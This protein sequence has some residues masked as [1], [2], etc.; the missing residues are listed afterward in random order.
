[1]VCMHA[2]AEESASGATTEPAGTLTTPGA[3][4]VWNTLDEAARTE[5]VRLLGCLIAKAVVPTDEVPVDNDQ[6]QSDE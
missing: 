4:P 6:E 3:R 5:A 1:M 2:Q